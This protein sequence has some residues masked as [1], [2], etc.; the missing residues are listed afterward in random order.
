MELDFGETARGQEEVVV[1]HEGQTDWGEDS[2][3]VATFNC[4]RLSWFGNF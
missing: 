2:L 4:I 3:V 1:G